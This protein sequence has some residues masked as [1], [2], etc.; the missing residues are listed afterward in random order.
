M[1]RDNPPAAAPSGFALMPPF[2][3]FHEL[4]GPMYYSLRAPTSVVGL[5]VQEK[6]RN[7][8]PNPMMHG[9]MMAALIDTA[10][11]WA[12]RHSQEPSVSTVTTN[13][14]VNLIGN[15]APG[16]WVEARVDVLKS[17]RRV[18][19]MNC[20]VWC[21]DRRI[22]QGSAQFQVLGPAAP[23]MPTYDGAAVA[24]AAG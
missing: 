9:G 14:T 8:S 11:T 16:D 21:G 20:D 17:G 24:A 15:A 10:C 22:A 18:V 19:F 6:H 4:V 1:N 3:P 5:R 2:G 7:R 12:G 13:L 23:G